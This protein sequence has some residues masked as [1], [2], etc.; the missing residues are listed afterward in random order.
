MLFDAAVLAIIVALIAGGRFSHLSRLDL[1][2]PLVFVA[3]FAL[4]LGITIL[5]VRGWQPIRPA[6]PALHLLSY[7]LL[8]AAV[9][10]N[11]RLWPMWI[12]ALGVVMNFVVIA[13]NGGAMPADADLVRA[14][15]RHRLLALTAAGR[16]PTHTL[17]DEGTRLP[18]LADSHLLPSPPTRFPR[19]CVFS[20][21]DVFITAGVVLLILRG[22][23]AFGWGRRE[24]TAAQ[25]SVP[26]SHA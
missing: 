9:V 10:A 14:S 13:A 12:A 18:F 26:Q 6:A 5:G 24:L 17:L 21:G 20:P 1:R 23:G 15:G 11:R 19:S 25:A 7:A 4:Q 3:A 22:M 8:F 2:W 16:Y